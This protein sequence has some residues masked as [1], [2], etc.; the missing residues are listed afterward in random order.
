MYI[1]QDIVQTFSIK[2]KKK[3]K[4]N[5]SENIIF[6]PT[7]FK[8]EKKKFSYIG[9]QA[10]WKCSRLFQHTIFFL[11]EP[12]LLALFVFVW[13]WHFFIPLVCLLLCPVSLTQYDL[14]SPPGLQLPHPEKGHYLSWEPLFAELQ[15]RVFWQHCRERSLTVWVLCSNQIY[16]FHQF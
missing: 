5:Y 16:I 3:K 14:S 8:T 6:Q 7:V 15:S 13:I 9:F 1:L 11:S 4:C 10:I 2:K 12:V